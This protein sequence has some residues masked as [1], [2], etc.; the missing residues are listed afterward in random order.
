MSKITTLSDFRQRLFMNFL[1]FAGLAVAVRASTGTFKLI[2]L[3]SLIRANHSLK[4]FPCTE[5][6][7]LIN[8][9]NSV[10]YK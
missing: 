4:E 3:S 2:D 5:S 9:A 10:V 8:D 6:Y 1:V 7:P